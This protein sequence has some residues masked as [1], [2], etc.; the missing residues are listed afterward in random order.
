MSL[1]TNMQC[2]IYTSVYQ[3]RKIYMIARLYE[4]KHSIR[5]IARF[6]IYTSTWFRIYTSTWIT[7]K[8][9]RY[10]DRFW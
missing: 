10:R 7:G 3:D 2:T 6:R 8:G 5:L 4:F 9:A 1:S